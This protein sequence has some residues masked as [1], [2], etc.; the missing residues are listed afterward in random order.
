MHRLVLLI[1]GFVFLQWMVP[2]AQALE[3]MDMELVV[4]GTGYPYPMADRAGPSCAVIVG[5]RVFVVDAGR[6][7]VLRLAA[8]DISWDSISAAF[9]THLHSDHI[10]GLPDLFHTTWQFGDGRPFDLYGPEGIGGVADAILKFYEA[11]IHIRRD[12]TEKL[13]PEGATIRVHTVKDGSTLVLPGGLKVTAF[14]VNHHPVE[15]SFGYRF[16]MGSSSIVFSG[17]T[18]PNPNLV[19]YAQGADIL[20]HEAFAGKGSRSDGG[21]QR[22]GIFDY[23]TSAAEAGETAEKAHVKTLVLTHLIPGN[24][25]ERQFLEEAQKTFRGRVVVGRDL[26]RLRVPGGS[27]GNFPQ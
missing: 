8:L 13:P 24:A 16:D 23:H 3:N 27:E 15:P 6:G 14:A 19:Q 25:P 22:W 12:L 7:T 21:T 26:L 11:D 9:V 4:L 18:R 1:A 20:V 10:D 17:D 2:P 5:G